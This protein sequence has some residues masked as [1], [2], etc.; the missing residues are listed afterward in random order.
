MHCAAK[1]CQP[2]PHPQAFSFH[3]SLGGGGGWL[4]SAND[5]RPIP[6]GRARG[7][8]RREIL[9]RHVFLAHFPPECRLN[10]ARL[11]DLAFGLCKV[12]NR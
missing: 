2:S 4:A 11:M 5:L 7:Y 8:I 12:E 3:L 6:S 10:L 1:A 9:F